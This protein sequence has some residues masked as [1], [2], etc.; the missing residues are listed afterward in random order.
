MSDCLFMTITPAVPRP[1]FYS[2]KESKSMS[3]SSQSFLES[4]LTDEP[5]GIIASKLSHPPY[6]PP[7]CFSISSFKGML[8]S[9]STVQGLF[10]WPEIQNNLTPVLFFHPREENQLAPLRIMLEIT[11]TVSTL[12]TVVGHP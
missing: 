9:S 2:F 10:T 5:P 8:I 12:V 11:D 4:I 7:A 3:T 6:T 1:L